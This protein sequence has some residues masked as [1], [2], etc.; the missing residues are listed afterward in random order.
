MK[1]TPGSAAR[2]YRDGKELVGIYEVPRDGEA[3]EIRDLAPGAYEARD[4]CG[5]KHRFL[6]QLGD[7][8]VLMAET[9]V[10]KDTIAPDAR[11][12]E[13]AAGSA[14]YDEDPGEVVGAPGDSASE[15]VL[16]AVRELPEDEQRLHGLPVE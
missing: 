4:E 16:E 7:E 6:V 2:V 13:G 11:E 12:V 8:A 15:A 3:L 1:L 14:R 5:K 10:H 9:S